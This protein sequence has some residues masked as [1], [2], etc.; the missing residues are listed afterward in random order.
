[1]KTEN[2]IV[3]FDGGQF[4]QWTGMLSF[5]QSGDMLN[6]D[7]YVGCLVNYNGAGA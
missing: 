1:M 7:M 6:N 2:Y 4:D 5:D 3:T